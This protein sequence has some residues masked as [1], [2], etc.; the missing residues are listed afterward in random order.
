MTL[1]ALT[2]AAVR[3]PMAIELHERKERTRNARWPGKAP[4]GGCRLGR[5]ETPQEQLQAAKRSIPA[6]IPY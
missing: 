5:E 4:I 2:F 1:L 3:D 6:L